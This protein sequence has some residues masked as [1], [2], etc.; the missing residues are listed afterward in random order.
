[1]SDMRTDAVLEVKNLKMRIESVSSRLD[2][3]ERRGRA[4]EGGVR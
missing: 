2:F 1:M 4:L 3:D